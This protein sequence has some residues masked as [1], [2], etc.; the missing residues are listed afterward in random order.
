MKK[1]SLDALLL[2][3]LVVARIRVD[4]VVGLV[5]PRPLELLERVPL[6]PANSLRMLEDWLIDPYSLLLITATF[7]CLLIYLVLDWF[8]QQLDEGR[9]YRSK[10]FLI[11][12]IILCTVVAQSGLLIYLR[13]LQGPAS[14]THDG[15]VIQTEEAANYVLQGKNPYV[16]DYTDTPMAEWGTDLK[17]A[18]NHF[19]YLPWTFLSAIPFQLTAQGLF[20]WYDQRLVYLLLFLIMMWLVPKLTPDLTDKLCLT[21]ILA[22]NPIMGS[23]II[24]GQNDSFVLFWIVLFAY[25][26]LRHK[27]TLAG[28]GLGLAIA[29]KPTAWFLVPFFLVY[30]WGHTPQSESRAKILVNRLLPAIL[31]AA[32]LV[33]PFVAWDPGAMFDDVWRWSSGTAE[34]AYQIRGW[35]F[36]NVILAFN[37]VQSRLDYF[38]FWILEALFGIPLLLVLLWRQFARDNSVGAMLYGYALFSFVFLFFSRFLNENYIGY[39]LAC[40]ALGHYARMSISSETVTAA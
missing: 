13:Q 29:S 37:L 27:W 12:A 28:F 39:L 19:P 26:L 20:G 8:G 16:E 4:T 22:L 24:F 38:P 36:A 7:V 6:L 10:L 31:L 33:L 18:L 5:A 40:L 17:T 15:G 3:I 9:L 35:G 11:Y 1:R 14:F 30:L 34:T 21:M 2:F 23:D 32:V 25:G